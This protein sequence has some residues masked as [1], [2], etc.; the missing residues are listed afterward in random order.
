M[1]NVERLPVKR[2]LK[3]SQYVQTYCK[4]NL[5]ILHSDGLLFFFLT[6]LSESLK[7]WDYRVSV[8]LKA[9]Y[10]FKLL[11]DSSKSFSQIKLL[12]HINGDRLN[13]SNLITSIIAYTNKNLRVKLVFVKVRNSKDWICIVSTDLNLSP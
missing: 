2:K 12:K 3:F 7:R 13:K 11:K 9:I 6:T 10:K 8:L 4:S 5:C 1:L